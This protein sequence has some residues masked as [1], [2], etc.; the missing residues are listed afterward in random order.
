[1]ILLFKTASERAEAW[2]EALLALEPALDFRAWPDWGDT[3]EA[4]FAL[5]GQVPPGVRRP[6]GPFGDHYGYY[7]LTHDYPVFEVE[8]VAP[9]H[10]EAGALAPEVLKALLKAPVDLHRHHPRAGVREA[11]RQVAWASSDLEHGVVGAHIDGLGDAAQNAGVG[12]PVLADRRPRP[13]PTG[14][15]TR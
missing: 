11:P 3:G 9:R 7:S 13:G 2:R 12:E 15:L 14:L 5:I 10:G 1:M 6:E 4:E 8:H